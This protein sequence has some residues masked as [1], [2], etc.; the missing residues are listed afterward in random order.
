MLTELHISNF[1]IIEQQTISFGAGLNVISGETGAG[2]SIILSAIELILGGR[3]KAHFIRD[4]SD[5]LEVQAIFSLEGIEPE[6]RRSLPDLVEGSELAISR[7]VNRAGK[8]KVYLNGRLAT[9]GLLAEVVGRLVNICGQGQHIS[10]LEP[11]YHLMMVDEFAKNGALRAEYTALYDEWRK[12]LARLE[13]VE[14]RFA[15]SALRQAELEATI[16]ELESLQLAPGL[17]DELEGRVRALANA[18]RIMQ[19]CQSIAGA[20]EDEGVLTQLAAVSGSL[21]ELAKLDQ[22]LLPYCELL[23]SARAELAELAGDLSSHAAK[24]ELSEEAL[25]ELRERLATLARLERK[26]RCGE[27]GLIKILE[28]A[29][30]E[31]KLL[32]EGADLDKLRAKLASLEA[33]ACDSAARLGESRRRAADALASQV[34][35]ELADLSMTHAKLGARIEPAPLGPS[36][37]EKLELE[38]STNKGES[39]K[40]LRQI[41]SGGELAR[42][43]LVLKKIFRERTG[44][45]VLVFDEVDTG[46]S[47]SVARAVGEKLRALSRF[48]QVICI[49]HLAQV[50]SLADVHLLVGKKVGERTISIVKELGSEEKVEEIARMLAGYSVTQAARESARELLASKT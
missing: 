43:M 20:L 17:R 46:I 23:G 39:F 16:E 32:E 18:E 28:L 34:A 38:I 19:G 40:P 25:D 3:P 24:V 22:R 33:Q 14:E 47:G 31:R 36:G 50:A 13:E 8:G 11:S 6:V 48:S 12:A 42:I 21:H 15:R 9:V 26:Y 30:E 1:A 44:V 5:A 10:L 7:T 49:T 45:N 29:R 35:A 37:A 41:A 2:K 4:G 27:E